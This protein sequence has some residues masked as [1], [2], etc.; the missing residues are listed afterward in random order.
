MDTTKDERRLS[1][2]SNN[3]VLPQKPNYRK[4]ALIVSGAILIILIFGSGIVLGKYITKPNRQLVSEGQI[5]ENLVKGQGQK[6]MQKNKKRGLLGDVIKTEAD[7]ITIKGADG[8]EK[9]VITN[10]QTKIKKQ[11]SD[12]KIT[13]IKTGDRIMVVGK[14]NDQGVITA[15]MIKVMAPK[16]EGQFQ[17]ESSQ[18]QEMD[19]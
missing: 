17:Q 12:I 14:P 4:I 19:I 10:D 2:K 7:K 16:A 18:N 3:K 6:G 9:A 5:G 13:D 15:K 8:Q 1:V 11:G